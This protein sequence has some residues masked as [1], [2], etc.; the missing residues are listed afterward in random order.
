VA[1]DLIF[2]DESIFNKKTG[3]RY[4]AYA[5]IGDEARYTTD[6]TRGWTWAIC[7]AMTLG[8]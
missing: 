7:S 2:L 3:W 8:G 6:I 5:P 4:N 1:E